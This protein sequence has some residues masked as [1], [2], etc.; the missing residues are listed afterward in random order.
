MCLAQHETRLELLATGIEERIVQQLPRNGHGPPRAKS[1]APNELDLNGPDHSATF[2]GRASVD[3]QLSIEESQKPTISSMEANFNRLSWLPDSAKR[4]TTT[5]SDGESYFSKT[6][7]MVYRD[8]Y[9]GSF[10][11]ADT[12]SLQSRRAVH[13][14]HDHKL[15]HEEEFEDEEEPE[16][17]RSMIFKFCLCFHVMWVPTLFLVVTLVALIRFSMDLAKYQNLPNSAISV[18]KDMTYNALAGKEIPYLDMPGNLTFTLMSDLFVRGRSHGVGC[19][20]SSLF[21]TIAR[22]PRPYNFS[23]DGSLEDCNDQLKLFAGN[24]SGQMMFGE[25]NKLFNSIWDSVYILF[26]IE[27]VSACFAAPRSYHA[28]PFIYFGMMKDD[29]DY[30]EAEKKKHGVT[31]SAASAAGDNPGDPEPWTAN[32]PDPV[33]SQF[34]MSL[35]TVA[36]VNF[37]LERSNTLEGE[38][39][40]RYSFAESNIQMIRDDIALLQIKP[41]MMEITQV[42]AQRP[43]SVKGVLIGGVLIAAIGLVARVYVVV[44]RSIALLGMLKGPS[45]KSAD[46]QARDSD[47]CDD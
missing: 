4:I 15:E 44:D 20:F 14:G 33:G 9:R 43:D 28:K 19:R 25:G 17:R 3:S 34:Q 45:D 27:N 26:Q 1:T 36:K 41:Q 10:L 37:R 16:R 31:V 24:D 13:H 29:L 47:D 11:V 5:N 32:N 7:K 38:R 40:S 42:D 2:I 21:C 46:E 8:A 6:M 30:S 23:L 18:E 39:S 35:G 12:H 22:D